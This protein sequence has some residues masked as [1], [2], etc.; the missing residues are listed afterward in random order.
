MKLLHEICFNC[1]KVL[2]GDPS[3]KQNKIKLDN[4]QQV[5]DIV[6]KN[7]NLL[8]ELFSKDRTHV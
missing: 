7:N 4:V 6:M 3:I 1:L 2:K 8:S 5:L